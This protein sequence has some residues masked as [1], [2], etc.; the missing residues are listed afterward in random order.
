MSQVPNYIRLPPNSPVLLQLS[1]VYN[2]V[3]IDF[4]KPT[5]K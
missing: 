5:P 3:D 1:I 4:D 2:T